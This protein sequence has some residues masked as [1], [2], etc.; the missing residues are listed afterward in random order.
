MRTV[1]FLSNK[2]A[3]TAETLGHSLLAQ[4][5]KAKFEEITLPYID[6]VAKAEA[7]AERINRV[8]SQS[9][10]WP[11]VFSTLADPTIRAI[12]NKC[13]ALV[14]DPFEVFLQPISN[15]IEE[16]PIEKPGQSHRIADLQSYETRIDAI[17]YTL[18]HDDGATT[19]HYDRADV[20]IVGVS[21]TAKTPT[22]LYMALQFGVRAAN[23]PITEEDM[24]AE[25]LPAI[26]R[27]FRHKIF[28]LTTE[29]ERLHTIRQERRPDSR[30]ASL[31]QCRFEIGAAEY[32]YQLER[33]PFMNTA[34]M[35]VEEIATTILQHPGISRRG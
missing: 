27:P 26:I 20:I 23:F 34:T 13:Q 19:S 2:T 31:E 29:A 15:V 30:Y 9:H 4:F 11:L 24:E 17:E 14:M 32:M 16:A 7:A 8:S 12:I 25:K 28:G 5:P 35:S 1:F 21:R 6:S 33:V 18:T 3:I 22:C 10:E